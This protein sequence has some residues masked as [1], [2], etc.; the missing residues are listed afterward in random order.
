MHDGFPNRAM[1]KPAL[2]VMT[3]ALVIAAIEWGRLSGTIV[4]IPFLLLYSS[5]VVSG[6]AA[7]KLAG[8]LSGGLAAAYIV[9]AATIGFG[10]R[11]LTGGEIQILLGSLLYISTG[12]LLGRVRDQRDRFLDDTRRHE[13]KLESEILARTENLRKSEEALQSSEEIF[14]QMAENISEVFWLNSPAKSQVIYVSPAYERI[15]GRTR[16]SLYD[17]PG[18]FMETIHPEDRDRVQAAFKKQMQGDYDEQYRVIWPDGAVRHIRSRAFPVRN[19]DGEIYRVAGISEDITEQR[20][21]EEQLLQAQKMEA[22]GQLTGGIAH[23]FNNLLMV[24][25][26]NLELL[27]R[28]LADNTPLRRYTST[29]M[30]SVRRGAELTGNLLAFSRKQGL[31]FVSVKMNELVL[32]MRD[33]LQRILGE[34]M[35]LRTELAKDLWW[36][37][38][39][40]GQIE[41]A[42]LNLALNARH[43]MPNGGTIIVRTSNRT[44]DARTL[45]ADCTPGD[46]VTLE[47]IDTGSGMPPEV[48]EHAF[49]PF[50]TTKGVGEGTGLGLSM[51]HG[52]AR[53]SG[54]FA[55]IESQ[56]GKGSCI[57]VSLPRAS[58]P[59]VEPNKSTEGI[60]QAGS[61]G[62]TVL[63][64]EDDPDV[65]EIAAGILTEIG[66]IS[67]AV[68][69]GKTALSFL[70]ER[71]DID[72]LFTDVVLPGDM[73]GPD[74]A[75]EARR[76]A[77]GIKVV[78]TSGYSDGEIPDMALDEGQGW[79]IRKPYRRSELANLLNRVMQS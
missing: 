66:C 65:R 52:F 54:G 77:P 37:T 16:Q 21:R 28:Q 78:F 31:S 27:D 50:F 29:A 3:T 22:V 79:F 71:Q 39:D 11:T 63:V 8:G 2:L 10:P 5:V 55:E 60:P 69:D 33:M 32:G 18:S 67:I 4:P 42:L 41:N 40:P 76:M 19:D 72:V 15:W 24:V 47:V 45:D 53:Q 34:T 62:A 61:L 14:R 44:V 9:H 35:D 73:S 48:I 25:S 1:I 17:N 26:G 20:H 6:G 7:G 38:A 12:L 75:M 23:E 74:I 58:G 51:V 46:Y 13:A 70:N 59:V 36:I 68:E 64:V 57:R 49:E 43:A 56:V 30:T